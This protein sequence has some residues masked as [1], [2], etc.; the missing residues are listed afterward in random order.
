MQALFLNQ[1]RFVSSQSNSTMLH[2][3]V[4]NLV[5]GKPRQ[6]KRYGDTYFLDEV[7]VKTQG[8]H[9]YLWR[10]ID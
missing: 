8:K 10:A 9:R 2:L 4:S 1:L 5:P 7:F 6:H 3:G